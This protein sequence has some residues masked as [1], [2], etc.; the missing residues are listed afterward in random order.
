MDDVVYT[1]V[2]EGA[3]L[4]LIHGVGHRRQAWDPVVP[5]LAPHRD[6]IAVDLPGF[7]ESPHRDGAYGIEPALETFARLFRRLGI[8]KP[9]VAGNSL[10]GLLSLALGEAGLVRSV[11][12]LS[13]AGLWT[14]WQQHYALTVLRTLH[15][16]ARHT[17]ERRVRQL[18]TTAAGRKALTGLIYANPAV[19]TPQVVVDDVRALGR[20]EGFLPTL[21][22]AKGGFHFTG[23][24]RDDVPVTIAWAERDRVLARPKAEAL[25]AVA[26][27]SRLITLR[28]CGHVPMSDAPDV[29]ARVL[30]DGSANAG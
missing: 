7:G 6:V 24:V 18:A 9:H 19:L 27:Q 2:G 3:P 15:T 21:A 4:V 16:L 26:P 29:V 23:P 20:A 8:E 14:A 11:T 12:A 10:G 1:R 17:P 13:P 30:L 28:G 22:Q 5:L 25:K